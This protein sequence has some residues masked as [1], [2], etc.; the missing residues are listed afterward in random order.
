MQ[1]YLL[2]HGLAEEPRPGSSDSDRAL[3]S[4]GRDKLR[5]VLKQARRAGAAPSLILS[6]PYRRALETA[7]VAVEVLGYGGKVVRTRALT[8]EASPF[9][10]WEEI[11]ARRD[12]PAILLASHE[13]LMS[14]M[15]AFLL[16]SPALQV[17]MKK[18]ALVRVDCDGFGPEARGVLKWMLTPAVVGD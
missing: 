12:E 16:T 10:A 1:I 13:P 17:D 9:G 6:S 15:V 5:R 2:R 18:A 14:S 3:T 11:R 4:E 7:D 8:P